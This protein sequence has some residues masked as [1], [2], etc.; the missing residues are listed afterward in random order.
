MMECLM[1]MLK[2]SEYI[3]GRHFFMTLLPLCR[4]H[5]IFF[6]QLFSCIRST[7]LGRIQNNIVFLYSF[8]IFDRR[9]N[10]NIFFFPFSIIK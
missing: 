3:N 9:M 1:F 8:V 7:F 5:Q 10:R 2:Y 6:S 4:I